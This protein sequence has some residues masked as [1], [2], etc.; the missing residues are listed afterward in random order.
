M[1]VTAIKCPKCSSIIY[2]RTRHDFRSCE[3]GKCSIDGGFEYTKVSADPECLD[4]LTTVRLNLD[5]S[6]QD[7]HDDW[8][9]KTDKYGLIKAKN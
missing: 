3:C 9:S 8:S 4:S 6:K 2:S 5:V 7:L 1:I